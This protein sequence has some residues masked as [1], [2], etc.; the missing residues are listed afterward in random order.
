M[1][2]AGPRTPAAARL[3]VVWRVTTRCNLSC[4]FCAY[5]RDLPFVRS[6]MSEPTA[7][8]LGLSLVRTRDASGA[9]MHVSFLGGE[10]FSWRPLLRIARDLRE[11][12]ISLGVTTNGV[13]LGRPAVRELLLDCFDELT[14]SIDGVGAVHDGLRGWPGG[15]EL[16]STA[17]RDIVHEKESRGKGPL[18]RVNTVLMRD[19]VREFP[20][21]CRALADLGVQEVTFNR[22]GGRDRPEFFQIHRLLPADLERL[23]EGL[24]A[25]RCELA[26]RGLAILGADAYLERLMSLERGERVAV[27]DCE[28]GRRFL[29]VDE[30]GRIAPCSFTLEAYGEKA[31]EPSQPARDF[32]ELPRRFLARQQSE[33]A[34]ACDDCASTRVF[35]KFGGP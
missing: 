9:S 15:F 26:A 22:L 33:R 30:R 21:L 2:D 25:L 1:A 20:A 3:V 13:S 16:L 18:V 11:Q 29:F 5:D 34:G 10:P 17:L 27:R 7:R 31:A 24:P 12:G 23:T 32:V 14:L 28:P 8:A 35:E 4:G 6:E 19:N